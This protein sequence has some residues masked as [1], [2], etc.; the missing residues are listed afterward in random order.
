M[1]SSFICNL[2]TLPYPV[3]ASFKAIESLDK[4]DDT[5]WLTFWVV[6]ACATTIESF[7]DIFIFWIP[8]YFEIKLGFFIL[9]QLPGLNLSNQIYIFYIEPYLIQKQI[10]ID[11]FITN[12]IKQASITLTQKAINYINPIRLIQ[13]YQNK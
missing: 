6:W 10:L 13:I 12:N 8:F 4:K 5:Q 3:Y 11:N 2:L 1:L 9:L 7:T